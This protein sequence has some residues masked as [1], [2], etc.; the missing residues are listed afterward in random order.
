MKYNSRHTDWFT[1]PTSGKAVVKILELCTGDIVT[2]YEVMSRDESGVY[3]VSESFDGDKYDKAVA[4]AEKIAT[5][6]S[7]IRTIKN[8]KWDHGKDKWTAKAVGA[9]FTIV[10]DGGEG[11][12]PWS[13][14]DGDDFVA[15]DA[16]HSFLKEIL[17][18]YLLEFFGYTA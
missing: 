14:Y 16:S 13:L 10:K 12:E 7:T 11:E 9:T 3:H 8:I 6:I 4:Y 17:E 1:N 15:G 5:D 2:D 18:V